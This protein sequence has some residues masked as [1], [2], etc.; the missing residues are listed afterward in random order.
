MRADYRHV[1]LALAALLTATTVS[2]DAQELGVLAHPSVESGT[3]LDAEAQGVTS[4]PGTNP[5]QR[6]PAC[7][8]MFLKADW[9]LTS[10]QRACDWVQNRM[11]SMS[12]ITGAAWSS[13]SSMVLDRD[14]EI[15]DSF[16]TRFGHKYT[17]SAIK[18][19]AAY[20]G[21][22]AFREDPRD[23]P[24]Y[25]VLD[26]R[27]KPRGFLKRTGHAIAGNFTAYRCVS[28]CTEP[29]HVRRVFALSRITGSLASGAASQLWEPGG[30]PTGSRAWRGAASAW[31]STFVSALFAEF[32]PEL[33]A[34][35]NKAF[36]GVFGGR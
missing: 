19:T 35:G 2:A 32:R 33:S 11:L 12:A 16:A 25:L 13:A 8:S 4:V 5:H 31:G 26:T 10:K 6:R 34:I 21:G 9:Q 14:S 23:R 15:G 28:T 30:K 27:P 24:P 7:A 20:L 29:E 3:L 18:S 1:T 17:Q 22:L 36:R